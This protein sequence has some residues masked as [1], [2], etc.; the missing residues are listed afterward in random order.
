MTPLTK[1]SFE[2]ADEKAF[3]NWCEQIYELMFINT[4]VR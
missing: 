4:N 3:I 2:G 1:I